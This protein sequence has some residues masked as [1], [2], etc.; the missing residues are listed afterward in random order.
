[1]SRHTVCRANDELDPTSDYEIVDAEIVEDARAVVDEF[2]IVPERSL[3]SLSTL[4]P[5]TAGC[6]ACSQAGRH[7]TP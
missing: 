1:M 7:E 6:V 5:T 3:D 2:D 4:V